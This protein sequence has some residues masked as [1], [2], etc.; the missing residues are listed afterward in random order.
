MANIAAVVNTSFFYGLSLLVIKI[1]KQKMV[2]IVKHWNLNHELWKYVS[3]I[4]YCVWS[5]IIIWKTGMTLLPDLLGDSSG[6]EDEKFILLEIVSKIVRLLLKIH[7]TW[8]SI[9]KN[10]N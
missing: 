2:L 1:D 8:W 10:C 6:K 7:L 4:L 3:L 9:I 5:D